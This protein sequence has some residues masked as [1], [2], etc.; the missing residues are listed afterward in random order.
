MA[1]T[2]KNNSFLH[3]I[4]TIS[5]WYTE[6]QNIPAQLKKSLE[7]EKD[8]ALRHIRTL[9]DHLKKAKDQQSKVKAQHVNANK[10]L[11]DRPTDAAHAIVK[12]YHSKYQTMRNRV[13]KIT[14]DIKA[15]KTQLSHAKLK[16][17]YF[18][19]LEKAFATVT[20][21]FTHK[22]SKKKTKKRR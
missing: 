14:V 10:R 7:V 19:A 18:H 3:P 5:Q 22:H 16:Q 21:I 9:S 8:A 20:K 11:R 17:K 6:A 2:K 15:A 1:K 13:E 4:D 12:K